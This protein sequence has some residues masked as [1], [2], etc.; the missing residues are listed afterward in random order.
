MPECSSRSLPRA[1]FRWKG[2]R[3]TGFETACLGVS[4]GAGVSAVTVSQAVTV[5]S[6]DSGRFFEQPNGAL[7]GQ[8][9][10]QEPTYLLK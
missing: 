9:I 5:P 10:G 1:G 4:A 2:V 7:G 6:V 8:G 3:D